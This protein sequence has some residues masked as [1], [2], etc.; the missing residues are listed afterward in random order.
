MSGR[1]GGLP[2]RLNCMPVW[3][4]AAITGQPESINLSFPLLRGL[5][6]GFFV[7]HRAPSSFPLVFLHTYVY[8]SGPFFGSL[9][10]IWRFISLYNESI[11]PSITLL[12]SVAPFPG[13]RFRPRIMCRILNRSSAGVYTRVDGFIAWSRLKSLQN[14]SMLASFKIEKF[15]ITWPSA[16]ANKHCLNGGIHLKTLRYM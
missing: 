9:L 15:E 7:C 2:S 8:T 12:F 10:F 13:A 1:R 14:I 16:M 11:R 6:R 3:L 4:W 5:G